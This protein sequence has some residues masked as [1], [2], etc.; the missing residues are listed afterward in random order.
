MKTTCYPSAEAETIL[1]AIASRRA[2][3]D[4]AVEQSVSR[5]L[6]A[7]RA[8]GDAALVRYTR[9][10]DAPGFSAAEL[11]VTEGEIEEAHR[12]IDPSFP[13]VLRDASENIRSFHEHQKRSS[14]FTTRPDGTILGQ[15]IRPVNAAGL[16]IPGGK[17]GETPLISSVLMNAIPA[18]IAGVEDIAMTTPPRSDGTV[19]PHLLVAARESGVTRIHKA[20]SAWAIGALAYGTSSIPRVDVVVG[21]G[22]LFVTTA[23]RMV[24][25]EVGIDLLAGPSE[26]LILADQNANADYIAAD[27]LSQA[28]HDPMAS[29]ILITT[30]EALAKAVRGSLASQLE[31]LPRRDI[32]ARAIAAFG[33][34]F[35][36][37][38]QD[39]AISLANRIA[40]EH[41]EVHVRDP[42]SLVGRIQNAGAIFLGEHSPEP[43]GDYFAGPNHVLPTSG[44]ARFASAL[45]VETFLKRTSVIACSKA[46]L[47]RDA[48]SIVRLAELEGLEAHARSA[49]IRGGSKS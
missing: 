48:P 32:A 34:I 4:P 1:S 25:G 23:K 21:P 43:V 22:N 8:E 29:A 7:V 24:S 13:R 27:L 19:N 18:R 26:I 12:L 36:V 46:A 39:T 30:D 16:Y 44:T 10:F 31:T 28:E 38:D 37:P 2:G 17:G 45:G 42:W 49:A 35:M 11:T 33:A 40:P 47:D 9:E 15:M 3:S 14:Y 5:I 41:L 20:G 6:E